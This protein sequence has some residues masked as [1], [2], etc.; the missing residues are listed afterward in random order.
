MADRLRSAVCVSER[1]EEP[2]SS[3]TRETLA[4]PRRPMP[5]GALS[6]RPATSRSPPPPAAETTRERPPLLGH[7]S[8]SSS[9]VG[10]TRSPPASPMVTSPPAEQAR[11]QRAEPAAAGEP[12][13]QP[14]QPTLPPACSHVH[15]RA[16]RERR[17][18]RESGVG[19]GRSA[20]LG[21]R[22]SSGSGAV[23]GSAPHASPPPL[24]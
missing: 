22:Q 20:T 8:G 24:P 11:G 23:G 6:R 1:K 9:R 12:P 4:L 10:Q 16:S 21:A 13:P 7:D 17:R 2:E 3:E 14:R 15:P 19:G 5:C 18:E